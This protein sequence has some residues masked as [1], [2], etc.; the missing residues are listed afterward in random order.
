VAHR[1]LIP[2]IA[3]LFALLMV[4]SSLWRTL[5][6]GLY[7]LINQ[8]LISVAYSREVPDQVCRT[9]RLGDA[10]SIENF[11]ADYVCEISSVY[12]SVAISSLAMTILDPSD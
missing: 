5:E 12:L 11:I 7:I 4:E 1:R 6:T 3:T 9:V 2:I 10:V 8:Y